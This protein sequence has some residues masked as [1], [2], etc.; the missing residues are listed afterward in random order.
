MT[1]R[2]APTPVLLY[3][4]DCGFCARSVQFVLA[5]ESPA[6]RAQLRFAP[7]QG[8]FGQRV[9]TAHPSLQRVDSVIWYDPTR[10]EPLVR[11]AAG[12]AVL[13]H[14]GGPWR[15]LAALGAL[16]PRALRDSIY[17]AIARN[18]HRLAGE[19]CLVP[20]AE[21]RARFLA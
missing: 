5:R 16:I 9:R 19:A 12:L 6:R 14:L 1:E 20:S 3:D 13:R 7:L 10:D 21:E 8:G 17:D 18:R 4:G 15:L 2:A 11:S